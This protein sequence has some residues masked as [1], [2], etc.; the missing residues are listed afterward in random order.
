MQVSVRTLAL[1][2]TS[3]WLCTGCDAINNSGKS[4]DERI[5]DAWP[6]SSDVNRR[7]DQLRKLLANDKERESLEN[8]LKSKLVIRALSCAGGYKPSFLHSRDEVRK[9]LKNTKC[10]ETSDQETAKWLGALRLAKLLEAPPLRS[11]SNNAVS[12]FATTFAV[13]TIKFAQAAPIALATS[14][15]SVEIID[16]SNGNSVYIDKDLSQHPSFVALSYNGRVFAVSNLEGLSIRSAEDG[17]LLGKFPDYQRMT[18]IEA[19]VAVGV[20]SNGRGAELINFSTDSRVA[21]KGTEAGATRIL[22]M[23]TSRPT[24]LISGY[25]SILKYELVRDDS[26]VQA[27]L[28][29]QKVGPPMSWSDNTSDATVNGRRFVQASNDLWVTDLETLETQQISLKPFSARSAT[30]LPN[31][32]Q[33]LIQGAMESGGSSKS[34]VYSIVDKTLSYVEDEQLNPERGYTAA[35]TV[36]I[37]SLKKV[38]VVTGT[39]VKLLTDIKSGPRYGIAAFGVMATEQLRAEQKELAL[40]NAQRQ[41]YRASEVV[42][43]IA[44]VEGP[45]AT[46]AK[47]AN[48]EAV[49]VYESANGSHGVNKARIAGVVNV[50]VRSSDKPTILVL[51]SYEPVNWRVTGSIS[52]LKA[53]LVSGYYDSNV[54]GIGDIKVVKIG[55]SHAYENQTSEYVK[56]QN[57]VIKWT[58]KTIN[59]FQGKYSGSSFMV[60]GKL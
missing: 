10:F 48:V 39:T 41:G 45:I 15:K 17:E 57:D 43:N 42:N 38:A 58:G 31:E 13:N 2:L 20:K 55:S 29:D 50:Y 35:R 1:V 56:L 33:V 54:T 47:N 49:G 27:R 32:Y 30:P 24:F 53:V 22:P 16:V 60:G 44:V 34:L 11:S 28:I 21:I 19:T 40:T 37:P 5:N 52:Q 46:A 14:N 18:W 26:G 51:A 6:V 3:V 12:I 9:N 8:E 7:A 4:D 59:T 36:Y 23:A 25:R